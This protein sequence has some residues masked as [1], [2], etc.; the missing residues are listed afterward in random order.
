MADATFKAYRIDSVTNRWV[1]DPAPTHTIIGVNQRNWLLNGLSNSTA[2]WKFIVS[3]VPFNPKI[4]RI[5]EAGLTVQNIVFS[6]AG[7]SGTGLRLS[8]SFAGYWGGYPNDIEALTSHISSNGITGVLVVSGDTHHNVMDDGTNSVY[9]EMNASGLSVTTTELAY[10]IAQFA[11]ILG[12]PPVRDSL[13]NGGGNGLNNTNFLNGF[14]KVEVF[15]SD[16][17]RYCIIDEDNQ[18]LSC[19]TIYADGSVY[20]PTSTNLA[21][22][23]SASEMSEMKI[24]PNPNNGEF[25]L[26]IKSRFSDDAAEL[27]LTDISGKV[28]Q[29]KEIEL[30]ENQSQTFSFKLSSEIA[31]GTYFAAIRNR[32]GAV[33]AVKSFQKI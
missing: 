6:I 14:G 26:E 8:A 3:G 1:Y 15:G 25:N 23:L 33:T 19:M 24:F 11:P 21:G 30:L 4:R 13:W 22:P 28:L 31:K 9:P 20:N 27:V 32:Q 18:A 17:V 16:S 5:I 12:Q 10:Q 7:E 29:K 2:D